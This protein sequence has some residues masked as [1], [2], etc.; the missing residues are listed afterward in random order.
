MSR[1]RLSGLVWQGALDNLVSAR[2]ERV[3][4]LKS[5]I[6]KVQPTD[7][8][9]AQLIDNRDAFLSS[10]ETADSPAPAEIV[11]LCGAA[12]NSGA[13]YLDVIQSFDEAAR[14]QV[15]EWLGTIVTAQQDRAQE[16][17]DQL[18]LPF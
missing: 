5:L 16:V 12:A 11:R 4:R 2:K 1:D 7:A 6:G 13:N 9:R 15:V 17:V 3:K 8:G 18:P 14:N 10:L